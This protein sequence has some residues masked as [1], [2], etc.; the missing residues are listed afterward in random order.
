MVKSEDSV[1]NRLIW[2]RHGGTRKKTNNPQN[3]VLLKG[4]T[5]MKMPVYDGCSHEK[6]DMESRNK[7]R[8]MLTELKCGRRNRGTHTTT[9]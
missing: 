2:F 9:R 5:P 3:G 8:T 6:T 1:I 4:K 7:I